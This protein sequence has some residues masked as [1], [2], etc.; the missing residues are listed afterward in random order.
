[1]SRQNCNSKSILFCRH[2]A[3]P[4][5]WEGMR[6]CG[7]THAYTNW[8]C[9]QEWQEEELPSLQLSLKSKSEL[10]VPMVVERKIQI[11]MQIYLKNS[12]GKKYI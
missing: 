10:P 3:C 8:H 2:I 11:M 6:A 5:A 4:M 9:W 12:N 1:M 7:L